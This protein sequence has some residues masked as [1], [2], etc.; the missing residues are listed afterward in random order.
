MDSEKPLTRDEIK[1][2]MEKIGDSFIFILGMMSKDFSQTDPGMNGIYMAFLKE[3]V[4]FHSKCDQHFGTDRAKVIT[5][6]MFDAISKLK[7]TEE[8]EKEE[9]SPDIVWEK[10]HSIKGKEEAPRCTH[11][12]IECFPESLHPGEMYLCPAD[13]HR[14]D[15]YTFPENY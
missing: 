10:E 5:S 6:R 1:D 3:T 15:Y 13:E 2:L 9:E 11:C 8:K 7:K 4:N 14:R 12:G